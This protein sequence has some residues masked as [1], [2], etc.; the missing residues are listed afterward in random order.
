ML[1]AR[2]AASY[3]SWA[4]LKQR[5]ASWF[6]S[7]KCCNKLRHAENGNTTEQILKDILLQ[8]GVPPDSVQHRVQHAIK[9]MG[10][11]ALQSDIEST[12]EPRDLWNRLKAHADR[13][14]FRWVT[15]DELQ[16]SSNKKGK[17]SVKPKRPSLGV[18]RSLIRGLK[19]VTP[20]LLLELMPR[21]MMQALLPQRVTT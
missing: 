5:A 2:H 6:M 4:C 8:H 20:G 7:N 10:L 18:V 12:P 3:Q 13:Y 17:N 9:I 1:G 19:T 15:R 11:S 14:N 21:R 16:H